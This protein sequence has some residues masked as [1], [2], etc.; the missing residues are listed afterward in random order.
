MPTMLERSLRRLCVT[1]VI[2]LVPSVA[3]ASETVLFNESAAF[4]CYQA[5]L[6][7]GDKYDIDTCTLA[8]DHQMLGAMD[9]AATF[10]NRGLIYARIGDLRAALSD[11]NR[12]VRIAPDVSS[13]YINR[14]N[15]F[16][17]AKQYERAMRDLEQAIDIA[18]EHLAYAHYNRALLFR[19]LGDGQ[20]ARGDAERAAAIAPERE[21][22]REFL[23]QLEAATGRPLDPD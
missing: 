5:A 7:E 11:H 9:R 18:D 4:E 17:R 10:S 6:H 2:V 16:I 22:Y 13:V 1:A 21:A 20:A 12:A 23:R 8:L 3:V 14:S 19:R 15:T